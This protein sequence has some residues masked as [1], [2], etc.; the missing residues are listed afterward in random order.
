[1]PTHAEH[2]RFAPVIRLVIES[3]RPSE[4][5]ESL[6]A[7]A[8]ALSASQC[9]CRGA[10]CKRD[11]Q[12]PEVRSEPQS[13]GP[14]QLMPREARAA[15]CAVVAAAREA[16]LPGA[17]NGATSLSWRATKKPRAARKRDFLQRGI[18]IARA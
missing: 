4:L 14:A 5:R 15:T 11:A 16:G 8:R 10:R 18:D 3:L 9:G 12:R 2:G 7:R 17:P 6:G 13:G 1:M